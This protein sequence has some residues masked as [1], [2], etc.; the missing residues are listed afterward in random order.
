M[1]IENLSKSEDFVKVLSVDFV[2]NIAPDY[3]AP[4]EML[5][6]DT[7]VRTI[8]DG[9][10][11]KIYE[12]E[13]KLNET[14]YVE[15]E[16]VPFSKYSQK[17]V[18]TIEASVT[19]YAKAVTEKAVRDHGAGAVTD[20]DKEF[21]GDVYEKLRGDLIGE[22]KKGTGT[23]TAGKDIKAAIAHA[24]GKLKAEASAKSYNNNMKIVIYCNTE[25]VYDYL[26]E[27]DNLPVVIGPTEFG[28]DYCENFL[29]YGA[30]IADGK[31]DRG[32]VYATFYSNLTAYGIDLE[33]VNSLGADYMIDSTG[34]IGVIHLFNVQKR[35]YETHLD[36]SFMLFPRYQN[37]IVKAEIT[38]TV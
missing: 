34:F 17:L 12:I 8:K 29:G 32:A 11:I 15:G 13:G 22:I 20:S 24:V 37:L 3:A 36:V 26:A 1:A 25:D 28:F 6:G 16:D 38:P 10:N 23:A 18:H 33:T 27:A 14:P 31:I 9:S 35:Q 7:D 2:E 4:L 5:L 21:I 19:P 30:L